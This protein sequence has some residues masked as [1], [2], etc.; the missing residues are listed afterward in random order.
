MIQPE[1]GRISAGGVADKN[2][3]SLMPEIVVAVEMAATA[4]D[5]ALSIHP[6][7][8]I[9]ETMMESAELYLII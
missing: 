8:T 6:H 7:P 5:L 2:A 1:T 4:K 9:S 3:G